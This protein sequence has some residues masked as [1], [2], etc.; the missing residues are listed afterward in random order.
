M[1][2]SA[3]GIF[4]RVKEEAA[5]K[6]R[7]RYGPE[8]AVETAE[9]LIQTA[10]SGCWTLQRIREAFPWLHD[11]TLSGLWRLLRRLKIRLRRGRPQLFSPD[12]NYLLLEQHLLRA[13][14][15]V[16]ANS[17]RVVLLFAD[18]FTYCHWPLVGRQWTRE[19]ES[20]P[21]AKRALPGERKRRIV[22]GLNAVDGR[23]TYRQAN[24]IGKDTFLAFLRQVNRAYPNADAIYVVLDNWPTHHAALIRQALAHELSR[25]RLVYLPTYSPWLNPIEKLWGWLKADLLNHHGF[26]GNWPQVI[27]LVTSFMDKLA[28][29]SPDLLKRVGLCGDGK[30]ASALVTGFASQ[31]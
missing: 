10:P 1:A 13:L 24:S 31:K 2:T 3:G 21:Q 7:L 29:G 30:L 4:D 16:A 9:G 20:R 23:V 8:V 5:L 18:E 6:E 15:E 28:E 19:D 14:V 17:P 11:Y 22:A 27:S 26:V 25:L 12:P